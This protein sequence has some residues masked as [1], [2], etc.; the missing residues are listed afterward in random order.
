MPK[1]RENHSETELVDT[2]D[3]CFSSENGVEPE[4]INGHADEKSITKPFDPTLIDVD[5][6]VVNL[7]YLIN[8]LEDEEID[9]QPDFQRSSDIWNNT[10]KSR[11]I[12][13]ILLGLPLPSFYFSEDPVSKK[14]SIV[15]GLQRLRAIKDF[16]LTPESPLVLSH[17][18]FLTDLEG[19][20]Y[21]DLARPEIKRIKSLKIILN[22]LRKETPNEVKYVIFQRVN[23]AGEPLNSQE[24]R[25]ALNQGPAAQFIKELAELESFQ[26]ATNYS[27]KSKR[28]QDR[29]LANRFVAFYL[30]LNEYNG[31]FELFL[32]ASMEKL[33]KMSPEERRSI[34]E[35][36]DDSM[37]CCVKLF[38]K[39][40]F[41]KKSE[42]D[43][44]NKITK[45]LYDTLSVNIALLS[46]QEKEK[47]VEHRQ[48]FNTELTKLFKKS[49]FQ[50][51][52]SSGTGKKQNVE[53]RFK[54]VKQII[55]KILK[56]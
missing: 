18:Q 23:T 43:K 36:F 13:S 33:N 47:L 25:H 54:K 37:T 6:E 32:N 12:E 30:Y 46:D 40:S 4:D 29:D 38:G 48:T 24:M 49:D 39:E 34:R 41:R 42:T 50:T 1:N 20:T 7:G 44:M 10:Q 9:L 3:R 51:A 27:V 19:K 28:M 35:A 2:Q 56:K 16:V 17:L 45:S 55:D 52:I 26:Q 21:A 8:M 53:T 14:R 11:L 22:T 5:I 31:E 15:D